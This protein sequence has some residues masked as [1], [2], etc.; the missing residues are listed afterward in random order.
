[1]PKIFQIEE[2]NKSVL[3]WKIEEPISYFLDQ[4][5]IDEKDLPSIWPD[6]NAQWITARF[7]LHALIE[8]PNIL[9][10]Q[11]QKPY[12]VNDH[13]YISISHSYD[14]AAVIVANKPCGIDIEKD[15]PR[16]Q[17]IASKFIT[18]EDLSKIQTSNTYSDHLYQIWC[19]KEA[20]YK[21]YGLGQ[22]D[23]KKNL[24]LEMNSILKEEKKFT[25]K[26]SKENITLTFNLHYEKINQLYHL[27]YGTVQ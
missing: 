7:L 9:K 27:V 20:M 6:R 26:L 12:L 18:S 24:L 13:R 11:Y 4:L 1:M 19:A 15:L 5:P 16:L 17:R 22:L 10:D 25:G 3:V 23:F 21:A 14:V 8:E 2:E